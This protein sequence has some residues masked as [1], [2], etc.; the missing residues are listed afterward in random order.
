MRKSDQ[1]PRLRFGPATT[2]G[3]PYVPDAQTRAGD[4]A[5]APAHYVAKLP[6]EG[7]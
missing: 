3:T 5:E 7:R 4:M 6:G 1:V 2:Q